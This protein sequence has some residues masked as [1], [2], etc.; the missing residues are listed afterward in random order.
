MLNTSLHRFGTVAF[1][2]LIARLVFAAEPESS[3]RGLDR[4]TIAD[5]KRHCATLA[6]DALEGREAGAN[7]GRAASAYLQTE[8]RKIDGLKSATSTGWVQEFG[9][10]RN[11][12]A[13]LPGSDPKL[14]DEIIL[15]GAHYDH[16]GRGNSTNSHGPFG[17]IHNGADDNASGTSALLEL[18]DAF[19][20]LTPAPRRTLLFAFW[21]AEEMGLLGSQHWVKQPTHPLKNVRQVINIDMLGRLREGKIIVVGWR[22]AQGLRNRLVRYNPAG[23]LFYEYEPNVIA[24]SD[25]HPFYTAGIPILHLDTGKHDDYHRPTDDA[26]KLNYDGIARMSELVYRLVEEFANEDAVPGFRREALTEQPPSLAKTLPVPVR[27][28]V[29]FDPNETA[30]DRATVAEVTSG[31]A[32]YQGGIRVGDRIT[33]L[34]H[35]NGGTVADLKTVVRV[36]KNPVSVTLERAGA[37]EPVEVQVNLPGDP[38]RVGV[39]WRID[40]AIPGTVVVT[41]VVADSP[42]DRAGVKVD[43]VIFRFAD[44]TVN[45]DAE[46]RSYLQT[47]R[48]PIELQVERHGVLKSISVKLYS[49]STE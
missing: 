22:S 38:L 5:L 30:K 2:C 18:A 28:G 14:R 6:S 27:L 37:T 45:S 33:K 25:H 48:G 15:I 10:F 39:A 20:S 7:G 36:A 11:V 26:D 21:D 42:A 34:A 40:E 19:A 43:D 12:L 46:F 32:A 16:V 4:I 35:W 13:V 41:Q 44:E 9:A 17:Y 1:F 29:A 24:D 8:L 49:P 31:S 3:T 23:D 47:A